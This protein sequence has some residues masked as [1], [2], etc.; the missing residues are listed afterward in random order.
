MVNVI[1]LI[2]VLSSNDGGMNTVVIPQASASQCNANVARFNNKILS[3]TR[4]D[5]GAKAYCVAGVK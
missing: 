3:T 4:Y 1:Y 2:L 5:K